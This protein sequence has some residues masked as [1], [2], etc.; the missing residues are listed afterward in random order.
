MVLVSPRRQ[1]RFSL[2]L[3]L[4]LGIIFVS[5][6]AVAATKMPRFVVDSMEDGV[7][8]DSEQLKGKVLLINF[9]ATWCPPCRKE[10]P[11]LMKL[12]EEFGAKNF[13][14]IGLSTD[15]GPQVVRKFVTRNNITYPVGMASNSIVRSF[16]NFSGIPTS[17]LIDQKG[18]VVKGYQGYVSHKILQADIAGL[19][20]P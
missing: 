15:N 13:T 5:A 7:R 19:L 4:L 16:G 1:G 8:I 9:W 6:P 18:N 3:L 12:Q 17:F 2:L 20:K 11:S 14:V 10:I